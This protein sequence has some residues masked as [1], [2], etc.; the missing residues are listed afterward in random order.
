MSMPSPSKLKVVTVGKRCSIDVPS[1]RAADLLALLRRHGIA[2]DTPEPSSSDMD[3][4]SL[5]RGA[6]AQK[7][8]SLLDAWA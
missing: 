3:N 1:A 7:V 6:D 2:S 4:I 8:Q 5:H